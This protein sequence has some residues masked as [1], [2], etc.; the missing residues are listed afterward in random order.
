MANAPIITIPIHKR[1]F[2]FIINL[3]KYPFKIKKKY[4]F[5]IAIIGVMFKK[6]KDPEL[7]FL[8]KRLIRIMMMLIVMPLFLGVAVNAFTIYQIK[9]PYDMPQKNKY[10]AFAERAS[11]PLYISGVFDGVG[12]IFKRGYL[13]VSKN[14]FDVTDFI[15]LFFGFAFSVLGAALASQNFLFEKAALIEVFLEDM[16]MTD[17]N[18][19]PWKVVFTPK[20]IY[21]EAYGHDP[22]KFIER[23][24]FW[25]NLGDFLPGEPITFSNDTTKFIIPKKYSLP[26]KIEFVYDRNVH[27]INEEK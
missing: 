24:N 14:P 19:K 3:I 22:G 17:I 18:S 7:D 23:S 13:I 10:V 15:P 6:I 5:Y 21:F 1:I 11:Q 12:K 2:R 27:V 26:E 8:K 25:N 20:Y 9:D 4:D 16:K